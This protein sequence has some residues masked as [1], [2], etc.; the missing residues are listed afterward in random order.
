MCFVQTCCCLT[1]LEEW[2][3]LC[4]F[5]RSKT[6]SQ[7]VLFPLKTK[8]TDIRA[9]VPEQG[10][11][12]ANQSQNRPAPIIDSKGFKGKTRQSVRRSTSTGFIS[13][14]T[15]SCSRGTQKANCG[16]IELYTV[17]LYAIVWLENWMDQQGKANIYS[18][19]IQLH[20]WRNENYPY[21]SK[22][23]KNV[24]EYWWFI[25]SNCLLCCFW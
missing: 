5:S 8:H 10:R 3:E 9:L 12:F 2:R 23:L 11:V 4:H 19:F 24:H 13:M 7:L 22:V 25:G 6:F 15:L 16:H 14:A 20:V 1:L 18:L 17:T 21:N